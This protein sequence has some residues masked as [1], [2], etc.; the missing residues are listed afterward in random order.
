VTLLM[1][2]DSESW[3]N[4]RRFR[5]LHE[6]GAMFAEIGRECGCGRTVRKYLAE[7]GTPCVPPSARRGLARSRW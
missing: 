4:L 5:T 7:D 3:M 2:L 6:S 1:I